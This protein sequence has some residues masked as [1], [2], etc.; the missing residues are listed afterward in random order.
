LIAN[1]AGAV[2]TNA[3]TEG[4]NPAMQ[5]NASSLHVD[6]T[7]TATGLSSSV[8][9]NDYPTAVWH[10]GSARSVNVNDATVGVTTITSAPT[11]AQV[12]IGAADINHSVEAPGVAPGSFVVAVS[13]STV[14]LSRK[15]V[16]GGG[17][18][19]VAL[20]ANTTSRAVVDGVTTAGSLTVT[21]ATAHF[22]AA[23]VGTFIGGGSLPDGG[24]IA[25]VVSTSQVT[26]ACTGC[27]GTWQTAIA[28]GTAIPLTI[29]PKNPSTSMRFVTDAAFASATSLSSASAHFAAT[30]L[31]QPVSG[32][33]VAAGTRIT[34]TASGGASATVGCP[35][36]P[37]LSG[38]GV[39][40]VTIGGAEKNA[41]A[42]NDVVGQES[43]QLTL[44]PLILPT[45]PP[46]SANKLSAYEIQLQWHNPGNYDIHVSASS[47]DHDFGGNQ[48]PGTSNAQLLFKTAPTTFS[49]YL[50]QN[51]TVSG[52]AATTT[53]WQVSFP[54]VPV[55]L[56]VCPG[57]GAATGWH[58]N[59]VSVTQA[60]VPTGT[61]PP[62]APQAVRA[63]L[64]R[65]QNTSQTYT[66]TTGATRGAFV[67]TG[68]GAANQPTNTNSCTLASPNSLGFP[69]GK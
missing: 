6:C 15:T 42:N 8:T 60:Q 54:F 17:T 34:A 3:C 4:M 63:L 27:I 33:G 51:T 19:K 48:M 22:V 69:C 7:F 39:H 40:K 47:T 52:T 65:P 67:A 41:P 64:P 18:G 20:V 25:A 68:A 43:L 55:T 36:A 5:S 58:F 61:G 10:S 46:C 28:G 62:G 49:G 11:S 32:A 24:T 44:N 29:S 59:P 16:A 53:G 31:S 45:A 37:C 9:I 1:P 21:S 35:V 38:A 50:L 57:Q 13:G 30:D 66:G 12:G 26:I 56:G 23:D 2:L 14:T